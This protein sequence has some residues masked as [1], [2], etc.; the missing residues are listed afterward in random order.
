[1]QG[2]KN[3]GNWAEIPV[4]TKSPHREE[5]DKGKVGYQVP[6]ETPNIRHKDIWK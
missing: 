3:L 2:P 6:K 5:T 1:M 4:T